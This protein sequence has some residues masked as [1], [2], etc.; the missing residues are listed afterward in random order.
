LN[1]QKPL[2]VEKD[3]LCADP[4]FMNIEKGD[5]RLKPESPAWKLGFKQTDISRVGLLPNHP[6]HPQLKANAGRSV[7][8]G[9]SDSAGL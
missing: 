1:Q 4:N 7:S 3:S 8:P 2:G 9:N 5:L 6:F